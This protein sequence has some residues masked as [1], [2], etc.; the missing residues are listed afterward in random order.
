MQLFI[1]LKYEF[2]AACIRDTDTDT[3]ILHGAA[4]SHRFSFFQGSI[5]L[6]LYSLQC[7]HKTCGI[8]YDL[9]IRKRLTGTDRIA[10]TD[11]PWSDSHLIC[12][13]IQKCLCR[14]TGLGNSE[15]AKCS[16]RR[17][18]GIVSCSLNF[19]V[20]VVIRTC[21]MGTCALQNRTAKRCECTC[22]RGNLCLY[23]HDISI[24]I[25][26]HG[27][28]HI[29]RMALRMNQQGFCS[30]Q[31]HLHRFLSSISEQRSQMLYCHIFL[32][33]ESAAYKCILYLYSVRS[34]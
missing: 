32:S 5:I 6:L 33:A 18:I 20:F 31:F 15:S 17:I 10:V 19:K 28:I 26:A 25:T 29:K 11:F 13:H 22:I 14:K 12:H 30:G 21:C 24:F 3:G 1:F 27:H 16:C 9:T 23:S 8:I 7:L 4:D 2:H 34:K